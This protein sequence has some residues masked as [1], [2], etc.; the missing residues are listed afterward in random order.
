MSV[1]TNKKEYR[2]KREKP[3]RKSRFILPSVILL[4]L[5]AAVGLFLVFRG[6]EEKPAGSGSESVD[7]S[8]IS[9]SAS[10]QQSSS[11]QGSVLPGGVEVEV[12]GG[13]SGEEGQPGVTIVVP[14][15]LTEPEK[16]TVALPYD[17]PGASIQLIAIGPYDGLYLEDGSDAAISNLAMLMLQ[18]TGAEALEYGNVRMEYEDTVLEFQVSAIPAGG[19]VM[20]QEAT[21]KSC[22]AGD[23]LSCTAEIATRP[24]LE[25]AEDM[26]AVADNGDGSLTVANLTEKDIATVRIF[27]KYYMEEE[28]TYIGG[29]TYT[30]KISDLKA[31]ESVVVSPSHYE[32]GASA[33]MMVRTYDT[34]A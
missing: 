30:A 17:I 2:G 9:G 12:I 23:L 18:N 28:N 27:Y 34:D 1:N 14:P 3:K 16:A 5:I 6:G 4:L 33:I 25:K 31:N 8:D 20:V 32:S 29:I 19:V 24:Q 15:T 26:V 10:S 7:H 22:A 13:N 21:G 11:S